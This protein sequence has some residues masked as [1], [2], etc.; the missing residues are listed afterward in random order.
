MTSHPSQAALFAAGRLRV[1]AFLAENPHIPAVAY[2]VV[3]LDRWRFGKTCA[4]YRSDTITICLP[5][6]GRLGLGGPAWSWPGHAVDRTPYGVV[7]HE[8]GHHVDMLL[9][10]ER[11]RYRGDFSQRIRSA[12]PKEAPLTGYCPDAGE[13]FAEMF[14]LFVTNPH[15][16]LAL[17]PSTYSNLLDA[18]LRPAHPFRSW[19]REL[20]ANGAP[21]RTI[22][23]AGRRI[24]SG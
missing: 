10:S 2:D 9:S 19:D 18:G 11:D 20:A 6:C 4:Y 23:A 8:L 21:E 17:R 1:D 12:S 14:R 16:L 24:I 13:W 3:P 15:L 7:A 5:V 22:R